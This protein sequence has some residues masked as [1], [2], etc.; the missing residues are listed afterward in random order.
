[1]DMAY[2]QH[3]LFTYGFQLK[4]RPLPP[5]S[6]ASSTTKR[7]MYSVYMH[8]LFQRDHIESLT[9]LVALHSPTTEE[10]Q[11]P[12][13]DE[14]EIGMSRVSTVTSET[15]G[16]VL[17]VP[18]PSTNES[19]SLQHP[20]VSMDVEQ[21]ITREIT[22]ESTASTTS[23]VPS[24]FV[25]TTSVTNLPTTSSEQSVIVPSTTAATTIAATITTP[26][27]PA[28]VNT[29]SQQAVL[30]Q[31]TGFENMLPSFLPNFMSS[32]LTPNPFQ[33]TPPPMFPSFFPS[34]GGGNGF[35]PSSLAVMSM[36]GYNPYLNNLN[37]MN[38]NNQFLASMNN[39]NMNGLNNNTTGFDYVNNNNNN[40][41][42]TG[43][44]INTINNNNYAQNL[45]SMMNGL[46]PYSMPPYPLSMPFGLQVPIPP[47]PVLSNTNTMYAA[48]HTNANSSN[49][50]ASNDAS[51]LLP[52]LSSFTPTSMTLLGNN[53]NHPHHANHTGGSGSGILPSVPSSLSGLP[54]PSTSLLPP[55]PSSSNTT[56]SNTYHNYHN[57]T[58]G[59]TNQYSHATSN[60]HNSNRTSSTN[61][62]VATRQYP[63]SLTS[64]FF[65][66]P[67]HLPI[68]N[69][70]A[71]LKRQQEIAAA[72]AATYSNTTNAINNQTI[73][74]TKRTNEDS[75]RN[76]PT[77]AVMNATM[78]TSSRKRST[79]R[80]N[81]NTIATAATALATTNTP[82][83]PSSDD[84]E[85]ASLGEDEFEEIVQKSKAINNPA[86]L[87]NIPT[88]ILS[89]QLIRDLIVNTNAAVVA[90]STVS[91]SS[92]KGKGNSSSSNKRRRTSSRN[93]KAAAAREEDEEEEE[94]NIILEE[95]DGEEDEVIVE[96]V[97]EGGDEDEEEED[98]V[99]GGNN[100]TKRSKRK[101]ATAESGK[102]NVA[103]ATIAT[104][105]V[106]E[107]DEETLKEEEID[108]IDL[109][110]PKVRR[111]YINIT[112]NS[113]GKLIDGAEA[114]IDIT[115]TSTTGEKLTKPNEKMGTT[116][117]GTSELDDETN[118]LQSVTV[119]QSSD[120]SKSVD[121]L[122]GS[123]HGKVFPSV[124]TLQLGFDTSNL[125]YGHTTTTSSSTG[126]VR[127][128]GST[129]EKVTSRVGEEYQAEIPGLLSKRQIQQDQKH[130]QAMVEYLPPVI[131]TQ[132][133]LPHS[134]KTLSTSSST[135]ASTTSGVILTTRSREPPSKDSISTTTTPVKSIKDA[136]GI[137]TEGPYKY[138]LWDPEELS[139]T[140]IKRIVQQTMDNAKL[141][142]CPVRGSIHRVKL[143]Y[144]QNSNKF[145]LCTI[146]DVI[147]LNPAHHHSHGM[148][149][150]ST[151]PINASKPSFNHKDVNTSSLIQV[152]DGEEVSKANKN[153]FDVCLMIVSC[154]WNRSI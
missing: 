63:D 103:A 104:T 11:S 56:S 92:K 143:S 60:N 147:N 9:E 17:G 114:T 33:P 14:E 153:I 40:N 87:Q 149:K 112:R 49:T 39:M 28:T 151:T 8:P 67:T 128:A 105:V 32:M 51:I 13:V 125:D 135:S 16:D 117:K 52:N 122:Y 71:L 62:V 68:S 36:M 99:E 64:S 79:G 146:L 42:N 78:T 110:E 142:W 129:F 58:T 44:N 101:A 113:E 140:E 91:S 65:K 41:N 100:S 86:S 20:V 150:T 47:P 108:H 154:V 3:E 139:N 130:Y 106:E 127:V 115:A 102:S 12:P 85:L 25:P 116:S 35:D 59:N 126:I 107:E 5:S 82:K 53:N 66:L 76:L 69:S 138:L 75:S 84:D 72:T 98:Q 2:F 120:S 54:Y 81:S 31:P 22:E 134:G 97:I 136:K 119:S 148:S 7:K 21:V 77:T 90:A 46:N 38:M 74:A 61:S 132:V 37:T 94:D 70:S 131:T 27:P 137:E 1:M 19:S 123:F 23:I 15:A 89:H 80:S 50:N 73:R 30:P 24:P 43:S 96:E 118:S 10:Q 93:G 141:L 29:N 145:R 95:E 109:R 121:C 83:V 152:Y 111:L 57:N 18:V 45:F 133:L 124:H 48:N 144:A 26:T 6:N 88:N 55:L 34:L 4:S